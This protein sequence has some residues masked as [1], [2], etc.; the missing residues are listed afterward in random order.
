MNRK[1]SNATC[2]LSSGLQSII[3]W[4]A[5]AANALWVTA[6]GIFFSGKRRAGN[7][8]VS[9]VLADD[10][11]ISM[12]ALFETLP[13][14]DELILTEHVNR[15]WNL[16]LA[17]D[18]TSESFVIGSAPLFVIRNQH[19]MYVVNYFSHNYF[20]NVEEVLDEVPELRLSNAIRAH[21]AW[22]SIDLVSDSQGL[23]PEHHYSMIGRLLSKM[24]NQNCA[25]LLL[26]DGMKL[27]PWDDSVDAFLASGSPIGDLCPS[28]PSVIRIDN[29]NPHLLAAVA[30]AKQCFPQFVAAFENHQRDEDRDERNRFAV[31]APITMAG[32]TE[33]IWINTTAIE[34]GILYG[35]LDNWPVELAGL[36][37]G[38]R[39][40]VAVSQI[41]DWTYNHGDRI[42]GGFTTRVIVQLARDHESYS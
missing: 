28:Q 14:V 30:I 41:N 15:A 20:E 21:Q 35:T 1:L 11:M 12:V 9:D 32:R 27:L 10:T 23:S 31:K 19:Q 18:Q 5:T 40:R 3:T 29:H 24:T 25:A 2:L 8:Q 39:V 26:P 7:Q 6:T 33:S 36:G 22:I 37:R 34:N 17:N 42:F 4:F 16:E 13:F 38:D